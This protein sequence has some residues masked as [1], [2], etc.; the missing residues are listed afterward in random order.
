MPS[1]ERWWVYLKVVSE[2]LYRSE[3]MMKMTGLFPGTGAY[4][5]QSRN[6]ASLANSF[7]LN[8]AWT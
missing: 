7:L 5:L 3:A 8:S 4:S 2:K 1:L 6:V